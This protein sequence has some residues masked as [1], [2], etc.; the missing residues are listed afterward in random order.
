MKIVGIYFPSAPWKRKKGACSGAKRSPWPRVHDRVEALKHMDDSFIEKL[1]ALFD[2]Y[3]TVIVKQCFLMV[4]FSSQYASIIEDCVQYAFLQA[5]LKHNKVLFYENPAGWL[6]VT[7]QRRLMT[8]IK[9]EKRHLA[10]EKKYNRMTLAS[11]PTQ[12]DTIE[13]WHR[14]ESLRQ[15]LRDILA[16]LS[17]T[18]LRVCQLYLQEG[19]SIDETAAIMHVDRVVVRGAVDRIH[20]KARRIQKQYAH[21]E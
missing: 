5:F 1:T 2:E 7:A 20:R 8:E 16:R 18:E 6:Y 4:G 15:L 10:I 19:H 17:A 13:C 11:S 21:A 12:V 9:R 3:Y 14:Q